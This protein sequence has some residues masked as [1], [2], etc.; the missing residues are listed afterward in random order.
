MV[1]FRAWHKEYKQMLIPS[2][3]CFKNGI[4]NFLFFE[5]ENEF[6][7]ATEPVA[8]ATSIELMQWTGLNDVTGK[9]IFEG[10]IVDRM[11]STINGDTHNIGII[12]FGEHETSDDYYAS[13]A[14]GFYIE[15]VI[16]PHQSTVDSLPHDN[17]RVVGNVWENSELLEEAK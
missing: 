9:C 12:K 6:N 15:Y 8:F 3:I 16:S 1:K 4:V 5:Y 10:D 11:F 17:L 13:T 14:Y 7:D 2:K